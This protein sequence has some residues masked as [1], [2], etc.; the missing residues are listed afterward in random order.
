MTEREP[1]RY[2]CPEGHTNWQ[3]RQSGIHHSEAPFYCMSC[4]DGDGL[5]PHFEKLTD[6]KTGKRVSGVQS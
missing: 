3:S 6:A 1:W 2:R 4:K 5:S